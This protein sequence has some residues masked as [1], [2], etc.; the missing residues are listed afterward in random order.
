M[1]LKDAKCLEQ[2]S[3]VK[4]CDS[5]IKFDAKSNPDYLEIAPDGKTRKNCRKT[6][7]IK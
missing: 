6:N 1:C 2:E 7:H 5:C 3:S 4:K